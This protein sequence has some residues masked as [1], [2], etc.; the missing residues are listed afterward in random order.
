MVYNGTSIQAT[1]RVP[2]NFFRGP[3]LRPHIMLRDLLTQKFVH[4]KRLLIL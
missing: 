3:Q 4:K 1:Y 2:Q